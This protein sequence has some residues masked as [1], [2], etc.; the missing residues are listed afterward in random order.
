[1]NFMRLA[2]CILYL[3]YLSPIFNW[4]ILST[5]WARHHTYSES[6][7]PAAMSRGYLSTAPF[8]ILW[9][10]YS[11]C[12]FLLQC[13]LSLVPPTA[14]FFYLHFHVGVQNVSGLGFQVG[15]LYVN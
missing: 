3:G 12:P 1:L 11:F 15:R 7:C 10:L 4:L 8:S 6:V 13:S 14:E 9:P 5:P 2:S